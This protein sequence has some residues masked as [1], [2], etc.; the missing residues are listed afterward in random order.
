MAE[1]QRKRGE[2]K[3]SRKTKQRKNA[4]EVVYTPAREFNHSRLVLNILT[5]VAVAFAI[6]LGLSIFFNVEQVTVSGADRYSEWTVVEAA[7]IEQGDSLLFFGEANAASKI[8]D[9]LPY[10]KAVRFEI[11]LPGTVHIIIEE[12]PVAY[13]LQAE[14]GSWWLM[15][16]QGRLTE[17][18][19]AA[20]AKDYALIE[21]ITLRAP[22]AGQDAVAAETGEGSVTGAD[23]LAAAL[24]IL[25]QLEHNE[26]FDKVTAVTVS[27]LQSLEFWYGDR[28]QVKLGNVSYMREKLAA[29]KSAVE[30]AGDYQTGILDASAVTDHLEG[31]TIPCIPFYQQS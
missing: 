4:P 2:T 3:N 10:V 24:E 21:G 27:K 28:F 13:C 30:L 5:I 25:T 8:I 11:Q 1:N 26:L 20:V 31:I 22:V 29:I 7:G 16:A 12:A 14:D 19:N 18:I 17:Q 9:A 23:R 15:T 6:F